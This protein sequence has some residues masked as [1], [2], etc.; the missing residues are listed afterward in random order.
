MGSVDRPPPRLA[1]GVSGAASPSTYYH[2][3]AVCCRALPPIAANGRDDYGRALYE[4]SLLITSP[5]A[6]KAHDYTVMREAESPLDQGVA[7]RFGV[8]THE[9]EKTAR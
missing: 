9:R 7:M 4:E 8:S 5:A 2:A 3:S 1:Y 6:S